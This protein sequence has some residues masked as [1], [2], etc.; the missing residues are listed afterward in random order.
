MDISIFALH[1][2]LWTA[3]QYFDEG[4]RV[5]DRAVLPCPNTCATHSLAII[6]YSVLHP[7]HRGRDPYK[8]LTYT[9]TSG[10]F[11]KKN[12]TKGR[13]EEREARWKDRAR[14]TKREMKKRNRDKERGEN[15]KKEERQRG[16]VDVLLL[17]DL[18][19]W[20]TLAWGWEGEE[21]RKREGRE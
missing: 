13:E 5:V 14:W 4:K 8:L 10:S 21:D 7:Q 20:P 2:Y 11:A 1:T 18:S 16:R 12:K 3:F 9:H 6:Y 15:T 17:A 19:Y